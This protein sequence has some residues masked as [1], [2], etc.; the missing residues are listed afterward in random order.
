MAD[1]VKRYHWVAMLLHWVVALLILA[2]L[3]LGILLDKIAIAD[4]AVYYPLH[5]SIGI[6]VLSL[7]VLRLGW[8]F[9]KPPP[10][11][12][13]ALTWWE[14]GLASLVHG[15]FY[16]LIIGVP[17]SGWLLVSASPKNIPTLL[18]NSILLPNLPFFAGVA[19]RKALAHSIGEIHGYLAY[20]M[21][22]LVVLH[23]AAAIKHHWLSKDET[24]LRMTPRFLNPLLRGL[25]GETKARSQ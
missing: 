22:A 4:R 24:L 20:S 11:Y 8:R 15:L 7:S 21:L 6:L 9:I 17:F 19:D 13:A 25:R 3:L 5:K 16:V 2:N 23:G 1:T 10:I 18:F 14:A 12:P